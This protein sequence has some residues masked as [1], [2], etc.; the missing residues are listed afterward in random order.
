MRVTQPLTSFLYRCRAGKPKVWR[1]MASISWLT[2]AVIAALPSAAHSPQHAAHSPSKSA[3]SK[4]RIPASPTAPSALRWTFRL[5]DTEKRVYDLPAVLVVPSERVIVDTEGGF[6]S[7]VVYGLRRD[8]GAQLWQT[9]KGHLLSLAL[10]PL[11]SEA[12]VFFVPQR[13][14]RAAYTQAVDAATGRDLW[15]RAQIET[16][17]VLIGVYGDV[18]AFAN[19]GGSQVQLV[20]TRTGQGLDPAH[21][22]ED[23]RLITAS[24]W[25]YGATQHVDLIGS[26]GLL[27]IS[28][29]TL[30]PFPL[31]K[32]VP[33]WENPEISPGGVELVMPSGRGEQTRVGAAASYDAFIV[34]VD[35]DNGMAGH[36]VWPKYLVG[37]KPDGIRR[38]QFPAQVSPPDKYDFADRMHA[39]WAV[40]QAGMVLTQNLNHTLFGVRM[41][42]GKKVWERVWHGSK[43]RVGRGLLQSVA[44]YDRGAFTLSVP[45]AELKREQGLRTAP[46][47]VRRALDYVDALTGAVY[48]IADLTLDTTPG[49][50]VPMSLSIEGDDLFVATPIGIRAFRCR[51]LLQ[52]AAVQTPALRRILARLPPR[53]TLTM[54]DG[55]PPNAASQQKGTQALAIN[56]AGQIVG[57]SRERPVMWQ[58]GRPRTLP[59][60]PGDNTGLAYAINGRGDILARSKHKF[61]SRDFLLTRGSRIVTFYTPDP[62]VRAALTGL[63][64]SGQVVG[65]WMAAGDVSANDP[66]RRTFAPRPF[67]WCNGV[68]TWLNQGHDPV[69]LLSALA[70]NDR[71]QVLAT[72]GSQSSYSGEQVGVGPVLWE[73]GYTRKLQGLTFEPLAFNDADLV[74][75]AVNATVENI[76]YHAVESHIPAVWQSGRE[77]WL[78]PGEAYDDYAARAVNRR[79]Q[80]VG[81][82]NRG[83]FVWQAGRFLPLAD[84]IPPESGWLLTSATGINDRGQ[85]VGYGLYYAGRDQKR[86]ITYNMTRAF[87]LTPASP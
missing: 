30:T 34:R 43:Q 14:T 47:P 21:S 70:V 26:P 62:K 31:A 35:E 78:T 75:G 42:D 11:H 81:D 59:M 41:R 71:G 13:N 76:D 72:M 7:R 74:V 55:L 77:T 24:V 27:D 1:G 39:A 52:Q 80:V 22:E 5:P 44:V 69:S 29:N 68:T 20:N 32:I 64:D 87:L 19:S 82:S 12:V 45:D 2:C 17:P 15:Q 4:L 9:G 8:S 33:V 65:Q 40:P 63:N 51:A 36:S 18:T 85:I 25:E 23:K 10:S 16:C 6:G 57:Q 60:L 38:W 73:N 49:R 46:F 53:Y 83:A 50:Y 54:L 37:L 58:N 66:F 79:G 28:K 48:R 56:N 86:A 61:T 84:L 67:I 3:A